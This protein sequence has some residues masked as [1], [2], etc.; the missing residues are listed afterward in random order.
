MG[1]EE[2][3][4]DG[5]GGEGQELRGGERRGGM[6]REGKGGFPKS[7]PLISSRSATAAA[8]CWLRVS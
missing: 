1:G 8:H 5:T 3:G 4:W 2:K 7:P 6:G